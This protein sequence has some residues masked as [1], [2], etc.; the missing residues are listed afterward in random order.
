RS[1]R[2]GKPPKEN[3]S[4]TCLGPGFRL[5]SGWLGFGFRISLRILVFAPFPK[6]TTSQTK[7]RAAWSG[8][9]PAARGISNSIQRRIMGNSAAGCITPAT[10]TVGLERT[11]Y[12]CPKFSPVIY[13]KKTTSQALC[14]QV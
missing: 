6:S 14:Q 13:K 10:K 1:S 2:R 7:N 4:R 12:D 11:I 5:A 8:D 9:D 3:Q